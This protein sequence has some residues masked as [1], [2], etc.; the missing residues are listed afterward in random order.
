MGLR[1]ELTH[2]IIHEI[3]KESKQKSPLDY[4]PRLVLD[5]EE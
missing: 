1:V 5:V 3:E 2:L 4:A